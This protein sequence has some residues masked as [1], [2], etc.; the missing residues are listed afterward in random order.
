MTVTR[1]GSFSRLAIGREDASWAHETWSWFAE[2][3]GTG[4]ELAI[5]P[6]CGFQDRGD[7][8]PLDFEEQLAM[9]ILG[10]AIDRRQPLPGELIRVLPPLRF[11]P[12]GHAAMAFCP[13]M[14]EAHAFLN[15][16]LESVA[17]SGF[18]KLMLFNA[19]PWSE[20]FI[21]VAGRD[22]RI[23]HGL[24]MFCVNLAGIGVDLASEKG[25]E[26]WAVQ[27]KEIDGGASEPL[28]QVADGLRGLLTEIL[29]RPPLPSR[30]AG[31]DQ[32]N[33]ET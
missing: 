1:L 11:L 23:A 33:T 3:K 17:L 14:E 32:R 21:D 8:L 30:G 15:E 7:H 19:N 22:G 18:R 28:A 20:A 12:R 27:W 16:V 10:C 5:L 29:E 13:G 24:Q 31:P 2:R 9:R 4:R 26:P 6:V 25:L